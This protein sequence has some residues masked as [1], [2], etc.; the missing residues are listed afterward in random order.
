[1][2][3]IPRRGSTSAESDET[4]TTVDGSRVHKTERQ[5][6]PIEFTQL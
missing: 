1:M 3:C 6:A 2:F 5:T 4:E